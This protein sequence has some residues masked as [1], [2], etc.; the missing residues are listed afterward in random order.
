MMID[1][2]DLELLNKAL[3]KT[4]S[5]N[6]LLEEIVNNSDDDSSTTFFFKHH[7]HHSV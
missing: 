6:L 4:L 5:P 7:H 1:E 2:M 3:E